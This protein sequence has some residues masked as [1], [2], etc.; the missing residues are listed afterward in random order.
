MLI[1]AAL[2]GW[3]PDAYAYRPF[4]S[5]DAAVAP[6]GEFEVELGPAGLVVERSHRTLIAPA[7]VLN[8]GLF[9]GCQWEPLVAPD[10]ELQKDVRAVEGRDLDGCDCVMHL[11]AISNDPMGDL[12]P[13][14]TLDINRDASI[15][16]AQ[17]AKRVGVPRFLFAGSC[18]IYGKGEKL[19]KLGAF[20]PERVVGQMLGMGD[21]VGLVEAAQAVVDQEEARRQQEKLAQGK[22]DLN[23]FRQQ[24]VQMKKMG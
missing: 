22:F 17:T 20:D 7:Y 21:I 3:C 12:D 13:Q 2:V 11:A 1:C 16:L 4:D 10:V 14:I 19:D 9:D 6:P 8:L 18:S 15:R 24:I 5:T 23:D